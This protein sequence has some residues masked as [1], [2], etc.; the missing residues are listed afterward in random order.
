MLIPYTLELIRL[1]REK[2]GNAIEVVAGG[3]V[4]DF[5][6][7]YDYMSAGAN[8]V[9]LGSVCFNWFKMKRILEK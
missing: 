3:G 6:A 5:P 9:A 1:V 4:S 8:H 7:V 2:G